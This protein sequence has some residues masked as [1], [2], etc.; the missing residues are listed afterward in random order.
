MFWTCFSTGSLYTLFTK[1]L[2]SAKHGWNYD[3]RSGTKVKTKIDG[4]HLHF[5]WAKKGYPNPPQPK[6]GSLY[7]DNSISC[8]WY[9]LFF[10]IYFIYFTCT[11]DWLSIDHPIFIQK[12]FF[13]HIQQVT[14][15]FSFFQ[16]V[17]SQIQR[18]VVYRNSKYFLIG[19]LLPIRSTTP[20]PHPL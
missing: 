12:L 16:P 4:L 10:L 15:A 11:N 14:F 5:R 9:S 2:L 8:T 7:E 1:K 13:V 3:Q 17:S 18:I 19:W 6:Y 20:L